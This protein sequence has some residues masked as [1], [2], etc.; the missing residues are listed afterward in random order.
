M[1]Y[2]IEGV[3]AIPFAWYVIYHNSVEFENEDIYES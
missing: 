1:F 2:K 3:L